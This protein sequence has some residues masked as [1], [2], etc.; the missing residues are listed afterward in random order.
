MKISL[1]RAAFIAAASVVQARQ[2]IRYYLNG[3]LIEKGPDNRPLIIATDGHRLVA[4]IDKHGELSDDM[5][6]QVI[7]QFSAETLRAAKQAKNLDKPIFIESIDTHGGNVTNL[8][9]VNI[10]GIQTCDS[11]TIDGTY[12]DWRRI[13]VNNKEPGNGWFNASYV[14]DFEKIARLLNEN[15]RGSING[16]TFRG[17]EPKSAATVYFDDAPYAFGILMPYRSKTENPS[18][19]SWAT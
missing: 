11:K 3:I 15:R 8:I 5:P 18:L 10:S 2:D 14:A 4:M 9:N 17:D 12:P 19:P 13:S 1:S 16:L 6:D 7:I